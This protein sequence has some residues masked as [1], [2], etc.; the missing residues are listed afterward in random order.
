MTSG[1]QETILQAVEGG[2]SWLRA[3]EVA[4]ID[5][6]RMLRVLDHARNDSC[7]AC[8][9]FFQRLREAGRVATDNSLKGCKND[10]VKEAV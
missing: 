6:E 7:P 4:G 2:S 5:L 1:Q 3:A 8:M 10:A 9:E